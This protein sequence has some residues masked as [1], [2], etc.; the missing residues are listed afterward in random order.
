LV[1]TE[2]RLATY[3]GSYSDTAPDVIGAVIADCAREWH[4]AL[5]GAHHRL[6]IDTERRLAGLVAR[7]VAA[8][9][10]EP[11]DAAPA[12]HAG[13]TLVDSH[14]TDSDVL[15]RTAR[16]LDG[17][18]PALAGRD[19]V[20]ARS[21]LVHVLAALSAGFA[22]ALRLRAS[23]EQHHLH[24]RLRHQAY[25]DALTGLPNRVLLAERIHQLFRLA[26]PGSRLGLCFLDLDG[27]KQV[28][29]VLG[30]DMGDRLL[31]AVADRMNGCVTAHGHLLARVGGDEFVILV[32]THAGP[33][34]AV[35]IADQVMRALATPFRVGEKELRVSASIGVVE[36]PVDATAPAELMRAADLTMYRAKVAGKGRWT[37]CD[38]DRGPHRVEVALTSLES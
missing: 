26:P 11:F 4:V 17:W 6:D 19:G 18:L 23:A 8:L 36:R 12:S 10:S 16:V 13:T 35:A 27:F 31:A 1:T 7:L 25:H 20:E 22:E 29:D 33:G 28:N 21:R 32:A 37:L 2:R 34:A 30:H 15:V 5:S 3:R 24:L 14:F 38:Q 9:R